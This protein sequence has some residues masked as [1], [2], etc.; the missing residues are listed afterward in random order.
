MKTLATS[1]G[2]MPL[3]PGWFGYFWNLLW[4]INFICSN[5]AGNHIESARKYKGLK[6]RGGKK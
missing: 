1:A 3:V 6:S 5:S 2:I 4:N